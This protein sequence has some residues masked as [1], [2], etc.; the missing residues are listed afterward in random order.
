MVGNVGSE[1]AVV[2]PANE[3][4]YSKTAKSSSKSDTAEAPSGRVN[5]SDSV[6]NAFEVINGAV[7][8]GIELT[9]EQ[10]DTLSKARNLLNAGFAPYAFAL[11]NQVALEVNTQTMALG[12][13]Q[14]KDADQLEKQYGALKKDNAAVTD[15]LKQFVNE[16]MPLDDPKHI[17]ALLKFL[18]ASGMFNQAE[19]DQLIAIEQNYESGDIELGYS[20][21]LALAEY[22]KVIVGAMNRIH[23]EASAKGEEPLFREG[24]IA[25][26]ERASVIQNATASLIVYRDAM[27]NPAVMTDDMKM[28]DAMVQ[29]EFVQK[30][31][32]TYNAARQSAA[33]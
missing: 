11:V 8:N 10:S 33:S 20:D 14:G 19:L 13:A 15:Q 18:E 28:N 7:N 27:F 26:F 4:A 30:L 12:N 6:D 16:E 24:F 32:N 31:F 1:G 21:E 3:D 23:D 22:N 25:D 9:P 5:W 17:A 2:S 29:F